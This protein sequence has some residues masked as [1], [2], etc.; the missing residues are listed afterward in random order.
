MGEHDEPYEI[1]GHQQPRRVTSGITVTVSARRVVKYEWTIVQGASEVRYPRR[2]EFL[3]ND[4][5][6]SVLLN[7]LK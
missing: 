5:G 7:V 3:E 6:R 2:L 1:T 4:T